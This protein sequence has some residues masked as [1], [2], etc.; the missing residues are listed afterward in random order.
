M[1]EIIISITIIFIISATIMMMMTLLVLFVHCVLFYLH[2]LLFYFSV[3]LFTQ[4]LALHTFFCPLIST[5]T[6]VCFISFYLWF[7]LHI[8]LFLQFSSYIVYF[9]TCCVTG[10]SLIFTSTV[11]SLHSLLVY[12]GIHSLKKYINNLCSW[13]FSPGL[14]KTNSIIAVIINRVVSS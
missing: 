5:I 6:P 8:L 11:H 10:H 1:M 13:F 2:L 14:S 7:H 12:P 4:C 9:F 3:F